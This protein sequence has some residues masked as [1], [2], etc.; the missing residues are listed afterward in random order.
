V[1]E[2]HVQI[3]ERAASHVWTTRMRF[4]VLVVPPSGQDRNRP[5]R[6]QASAV[7]TVH[8][9]LSLAVVYA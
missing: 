8:T 4:V 3:A 2:M 5:G 6:S 9:H 1:F 7:L